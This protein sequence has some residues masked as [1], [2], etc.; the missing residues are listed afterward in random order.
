MGGADVVEWGRNGGLGMIRLAQTEDLPRLLEIYQAARA[1]M[2]AN[3][4]DGQW[5]GGYPGVEVLT[6]DVELRR[7]YVIQDSAVTGGCFMF[8]PG[9]DAAYREIFGGKWG[10]EE[11]YGVIHRIAGDG[12]IKGILARAV[13]FAQQR[14]GYL[15]IDTHEKNT[16]MQRALAKQG[17]SYR[18]VI[19]LADGSPRLAYDRIYT[20]GVC[21]IKEEEHP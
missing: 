8:E 4:N 10:A 18:G 12:S 16:P 1:F 11:P 21:V 3:G 5:A 17:F 2:R 9:P 19:F 13:A 14:C 15:R 7:L 6:E 20:D